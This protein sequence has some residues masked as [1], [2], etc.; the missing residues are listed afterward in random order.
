MGNVRMESWERS[1]LTKG[2]SRQLSES[3]GASRRDV[4]PRKLWAVLKVRFRD[5]DELVDERGEVWDVWRK[6]EG[7]VLFN[8]NTKEV[9]DVPKPTE[10]L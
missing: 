3:S 8:P 7:Y 9:I 4:D 6:E 5:G 1:A 2:W 10:L